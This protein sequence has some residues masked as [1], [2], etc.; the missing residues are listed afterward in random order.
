MT[1]ENMTLENT[2]DINT[3]KNTLKKF[4]QN[5]KIISHDMSG[6]R[7][8]RKT[9]CLFISLIMTEFMLFAYIFFRPLPEDS[10][11]YNDVFSDIIII[12]LILKASV[13]FTI[14]FLCTVVIYD[15][16]KTHKNKHI[17]N[18][19]IDNISSYQDIINVI[20][21]IHNGYTWHTN[22]SM[23]HDLY[24]LDKLSET[25]EAYLWLT[26]NKIVSTEINIDKNSP[27]ETDGIIL[28]TQKTETGIIKSRI[29]NV[30]IEQ[31]PA[32]IQN[33]LIFTAWDEIKLVIPY[34]E[35]NDTVVGC[36]CSKL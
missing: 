24:D 23:E 3:I 16:A 5:V 21:Q 26:G 1:T 9:A 29:F 14:S 31:D 28:V 4:V 2:I 10:Q 18:E 22:K 19:N 33:K 7:K 35:G 36:Y 20:V 25:L 15:I 8:A 27:Y 6:D 12:L 17:L 30:K 34:K 11:N 32:I 13:I